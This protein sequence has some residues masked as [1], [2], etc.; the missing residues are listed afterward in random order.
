MWT[1][2]APLTRGPLCDPGLGHPQSIMD[3]AKAASP[4]CKL[5][6]RHRTLDPWAHLWFSGP[7]AQSPSLPA[8]LGTAP[9]TAWT[10]SIISP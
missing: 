9:S 2:E 6:C 10:P 4:L 3:P 8:P 5:A 1:E 7:Y